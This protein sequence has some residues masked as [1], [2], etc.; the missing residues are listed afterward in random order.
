MRAST[1][2][3]RVLVERPFSTSRASA[4]A[5]RVARA[6]QRPRRPRRSSTH[7]VARGGGDLRDA[8]AHR[9]GADHADDRVGAECARQR[10]WNTRLPLLDER[11][12]ALRV[13]VGA[14][15]LALQLD[16]ERELRVEVV[17]RTRR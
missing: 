14:A 11:A 16:L 4:F 12:D 5:D 6:V 10:P 8:A 3:A 17:R 2:S 15:R 13:V 9:A 7:A 1:A